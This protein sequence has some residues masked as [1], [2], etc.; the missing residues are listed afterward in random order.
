MGGG[1]AEEVAEVQ[2]LFE[3][4]LQQVSVQG[5]APALHQYAYHLT[6]WGAAPQFAGQLTTAYVCTGVSDFRWPPQL[7]AYSVILMLAGQPS[8]KEPSKTHHISQGM[9]L[10]LP[11]WSKGSMEM[12]LRAGTEPI[13]SGICDN[14]VGQQRF[15]AAARSHHAGC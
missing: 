5:Q 3:E 9:F 15:S 11:L 12:R 13:I 2:L 6:G 7:V 14:V 4:A 10:I 8:M 1:A